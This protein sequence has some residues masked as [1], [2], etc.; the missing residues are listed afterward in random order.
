MLT[1]CIDQQY[2]PERAVTGG[3]IYAENSNYLLITNSNFENLHNAIAGGAICVYQDMEL[4]SGK[5]VL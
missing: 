4:D 2:Y 1:T 5:C 3:G